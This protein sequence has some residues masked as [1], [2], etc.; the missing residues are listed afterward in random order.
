MVQGGGWR[1]DFSDPCIYPVILCIFPTPWLF[2]ITPFLMQM[3]LKV[4]FLVLLFSCFLIWLWPPDAK[5]WLTGKDPDAG[6]DWRQE[7]K[8]MTED[9]L[10][11]WHHRLNGHEFEQAPGVGDGQGSLACCS[12]WGHKESDTTERLNNNSVWTVTL[13]PHLMSDIDSQA[14]LSQNQTLRLS[15]CQA[16]WLSSSF[17][18][19]VESISPARKVWI[20]SHLFLIAHIQSVNGCYEPVGMLFHFSLILSIHQTDALAQ[21]L[22]PPWPVR[23]APCL[24]P[25]PSAH[26]SIDR[27]ACHK[28]RMPGPTQTHPTESEAAATG[29]PGASSAHLHSRTQPHACAS[30]FS[31][32]PCPGAPFKHGRLSRSKTEV[33]HKHGCKQQDLAPLKRLYTGSPTGSLGWKWYTASLGYKSIHVSPKKTMWFYCWTLIIYMWYVRRLFPLPFSCFYC[34]FS[35]FWVFPL[36]FIIFTFYIFFPIILRTNAYS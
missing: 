9:E 19:K 27:R 6:Q 17:F 24:P 1:P 35:C 4:L 13:L 18:L 23:P 20:F 36:D 11:G 14:N 29:F 28:C 3:C 7:E 15:I 25:G 32:P 33:E 2:C 30:P 22:P 5:S 31:A 16:S 21:T 34:H 26:I 8:G 10:V 12:P